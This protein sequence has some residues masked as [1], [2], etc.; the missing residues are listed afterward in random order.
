M[1]C[2]IRSCQSLFPPGLF[3][4]DLFHSSDDGSKRSTGRLDD[5]DEDPSYDH[6]EEWGSIEDKWLG[7]ESDK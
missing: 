4:A 2:P 6:E 1:I 5:D 3:V 7:I